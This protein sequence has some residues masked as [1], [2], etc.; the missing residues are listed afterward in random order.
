MI[1]TA[2]L[3]RGGNPKWRIQLSL[4]PINTITSLY[5]NAIDRAGLILSLWESG[6]TPFPIGVG[7]KGI[8]VDSTSAV[9]SFS[10]R[11]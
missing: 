5:F 7:R 6:T 1:L 11:A 2:G 8:P 9:T 10:A 4:A 3:N